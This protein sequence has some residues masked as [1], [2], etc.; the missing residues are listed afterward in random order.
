MT[1][2]NLSPGDAQQFYL[3]F[4]LNSPSTTGN[5]FLSIFTL[6]LSNLAVDWGKDYWLMTMKTNKYSKW[7]QN[8]SGHIANWSKEGDK[9]FADI[10]PE[11]T[12]ITMTIYPD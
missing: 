8:Y 10:S 6:G 1:I 2:T 12:D 7:F 5:I 3:N 4:S 11:D 9:W